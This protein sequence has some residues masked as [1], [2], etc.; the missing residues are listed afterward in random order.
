MISDKSI[1]RCL[2]DALSASVF[3]SSLFM[4]V[5]VDWSLRWQFIVKKRLDIRWE[6]RLIFLIGSSD[7]KE[8]IRWSGNSLRCSS[9]SCLL[10]CHPVGTFWHVHGWIFNVYIFLFWNMVVRHTKLF[11]CVKSSGNISSLLE[12]AWYSNLCTSMTPTWVS[13]SST[14]IRT[15]WFGTRLSKAERYL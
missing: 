9:T 4:T 15:L 12:D 8:I 11:S 2:R 6:S 1:V 5:W 7:V 3:V 13:I 10:V 14:I